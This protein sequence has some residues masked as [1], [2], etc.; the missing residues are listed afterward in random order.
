MKTLKKV[1]DYKRVKESEVA[2]Y[3]TK[4]YSYCPKSEWKTNVRDFDKATV[5]ETVTETTETVKPKKTKKNGK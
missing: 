3:L 2:S 1:L 5:A 4:G